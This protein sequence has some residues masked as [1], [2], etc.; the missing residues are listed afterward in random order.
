[1][2]AFL[3]MGAE[4]FL[5]LDVT[6]EGRQ[7]PRPGAR[8]GGFELVVTLGIFPFCSKTLIEIIC[9]AVHFKGLFA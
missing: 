2:I 9:R 6:E 1:M 7:T 4:A 8:N 3:N 5:D